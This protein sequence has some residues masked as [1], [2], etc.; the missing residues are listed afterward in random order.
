[1]PKEERVKEEPD[2]VKPISETRS[3][4]RRNARM[5]PSRKGPLSTLP[6]KT[7]LNREEQI[8]LKEKYWTRSAKK[9]AQ[10]DR[11]TP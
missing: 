4:I 11:G 6:M 5:T 9:V 7:V 2:T 10:L 1:M 8:K 3:L